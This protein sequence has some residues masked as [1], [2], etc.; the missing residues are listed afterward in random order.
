M[1]FLFYSR[2]YLTAAKVL[3]ANFCTISWSKEF[4]VSNCFT[5]DSYASS[6]IL[7]FYL[8]WFISSLCL[9]Y[10]PASYSFACYASATLTR[11]MAIYSLDS[12]TSDASC[13]TLAY[14][15][16]KVFSSID[17]SR[18]L[19]WYRFKVSV[20]VRSEERVRESLDRYGDSFNFS[21]GKS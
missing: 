2:W 19:A 14:S 5:N 16:R 9:W 3:F 10:A 8:I 20:S 4:W 21:D 18:S 11:I 15:K 13:T 12:L 1:L 7:L 6:S 17:S